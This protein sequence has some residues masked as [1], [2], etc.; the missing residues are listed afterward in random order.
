M[1][2]DSTVLYRPNINYRATTTDSF[3][4]TM[5]DGNGGTAIETITVRSF[6]AIAGDF[7]GLLEN[8]APSSLG[9]A[10]AVETPS[11][12]GRLTLTLNNRASFSARLEIDGAVF[13]FRGTLRGALTFQ[14]MLRVDGQETTLTLTYDDMSDRW[15][16]T[17]DGTGI[18]VQ[19][20]I[21]G[22]T[23]RS[24][25]LRTASAYRVNLAPRNTAAASGE[26]IFRVNRRGAVSVTGTLPNG[27]PFSSASRL[28]SNGSASIYGWVRK[29][30]GAVA[31]EVQLP[32]SATGTPAGALEWSNDGGGLLASDILDLVQAP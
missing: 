15:S 6:A 27:V 23:R 12:R 16:A 11:A 8:T 1:Q 28:D 18:S 10:S 22:I 32:S 30:A 13:R 9:L 25:K 26:A 20:D 7:Q 21:S 3:T 24:L 14:R 2:P 5:S 17:L 19:Q 29:T 4:V 31:G